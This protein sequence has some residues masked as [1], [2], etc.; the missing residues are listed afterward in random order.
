MFPGRELNSKEPN[1][2]LE[3]C[4]QGQLNSALNP[5]LLGQTATWPL[6]DHG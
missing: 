2:F 4:N 3:P 1:I 5:G 6:Q